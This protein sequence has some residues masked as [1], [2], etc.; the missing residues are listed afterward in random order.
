MAPDCP[1]RTMRGTISTPSRGSCYASSTPTESGST[2]ATRSA[3]AERPCSGTALTAGVCCDA[4]FQT[5][6]PPHGIAAIFFQAW[7]YVVWPIRFVI[8]KLS[9]AHVDASPTV[10][11]MILVA[12]LAIL[13]LV[14]I[15]I[16]KLGGDAA[17]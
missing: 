10:T 6:P 4:P 16:A 2:T 7:G 17:E 9:A 13:V 1:P 14:D 8:D 15:V 5:T 3:R 11:I 12:Y